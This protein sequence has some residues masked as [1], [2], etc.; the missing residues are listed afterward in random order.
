M[1]SVNPKS[2]CTEK[3]TIQTLTWFLLIKIARKHWT[4]GRLQKLY[5]SFRFLI[6]LDMTPCAYNARFRTRYQLKVL[7]HTRVALM[8]ALVIMSSSVA[9]GVNGFASMKVAILLKVTTT[10]RPRI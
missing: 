9:Y 6:N 4:N 5:H 1:Q 3:L 2:E 8:M 10:K 7:L